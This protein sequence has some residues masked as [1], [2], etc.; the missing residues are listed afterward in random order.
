MRL[1]GAQAVVKK[2]EVCVDHTPA[3]L[4]PGRSIEAEKPDPEDSPVPQKRLSG[5]QSLLTP[6]LKPVGKQGPE[7]TLIPNQGPEAE[8]PSLWSQVQ[9]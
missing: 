5:V 6:K 2:Y 3:A 7:N 8:N 1:K 4:A 9:L